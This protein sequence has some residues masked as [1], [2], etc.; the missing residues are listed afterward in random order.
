MIELYINNRLCD[1]DS[2][3]SVRLNRRLIN[4]EELA[5]KDS[6]YSYSVSLPSTHNNNEIF[7]YANTEETGNRFGGKYTAELTINGLRV[8]SGKFRLS[9][10]SRRGYKGNLYLPAPKTIRD[11]FGEKNMNENGSF[12][13]DFTPWSN[14]WNAIS[15]INK[16]GNYPAI[17]PLVLYGLLPKVPDREGNYSNR[18]I[19]DDTV[20]FGIEDIPPSVNVLETVKAVFRN[21]GYR[22]EGN[23]FDDERLA[24][25]YMSYK[26]PTD[27]VQPW[28]WGDLARVLVKGNF[29]SIRGFP[30]AESG[31]IFE[32]E[33]Y[34]AS[35]DLGEFYTVDLLNANNTVI[36][37]VE[38]AGTNTVF[39]QTNTDEND[40]RYV[41]KHLTVTVPRSG[42][43]K[44]RFKADIRLHV[45][46]EDTTVRDPGTGQN[47][48]GART[49][50]DS[51]RNNYFEKKRYEIEVLRDFG[52]GDFGLHSKV[53]SGTF[54]YPNF[55]QNS[56][57]SNGS[58]ANWPKWYPLR[59][60]VLFV[61][62]ASEEKLINGFRWGRSANDRNLG[63]EI[64]ERLP[65]FDP[66]N[67]KIG[68]VL[69]IKN[70]YSWDPKFEQTKK[71]IAATDWRNHYWSYDSEETANPN[72]TDA[73]DLVW[74]LKDKYRVAVTGADGTYINVPLAY[75]G[76][77][78][79]STVIWLDKGESLTV[80]LVT[81]AGDRRRSNHHTK[82][83]WGSVIIDDVNFELEINP[84][85][86]TP[87]WVKVNDYNVSTGP[88]SWDSPSDF[89]KGGIDLIKF[90]PS[91][92]KTNDFLENL[93]KAFN[94]QLTSKGGNLFSLDAYKKMVSPLYV[95]LD[96]I[97][98]VRERINTPLGLPSLYKI[99]FTSDTEE[100]GYF[101]TGENGGGEISTGS[102][103]DKT[104]EQKSFF[105]YNWFKDITGYFGPVS[106]PVISKHEVWEPSEEYGAAMTKRYTD[107][108][109][110]FWYANGVFPDFFPFGRAYVRLAKVKGLLEGRNILNYKDEKLT[111]TANYF[112]LLADG[113]SHYTE[114][115]G[116]L[117]PEQYERLNGS[118]SVMFNGDLYYV[119]ELS[120]YDPTGRN[121]TK[122]KLIRRI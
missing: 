96:G 46:G 58:T 97:T 101:L 104:V 116:Y 90:L 22:I 18:I 61:D 111:I 82:F 47:W 66:K 38:D 63:A 40:P 122:I 43:Y 94:L 28:P 92:I 77:G 85:K 11:I 7:G 121:K 10:I 99:G 109:L 48:I 120:G 65:E 93:C 70:G 55:N 68:A 25:L 78:Q 115:E 29:K 83:N 73:P 71:I 1:T 105:S 2:G 88:M 13:L 100:E 39:T 49:E 114:A 53:L 112:T 74:E 9:E 75:A 95:N 5:P 23:A 27:Y 56:D 84:F 30:G 54:N 37:A 24:G 98:S 60:G 91:E 117:T 72:D 17:F 52:T 6:Q 69:A 79:A 42:L 57:L 44:V 50:K 41:R 119:A 107:S 118:L 16:A 108:A 34:N 51:E 36:Q 33:L 32:R 86:I 4:P 3:F 59:N 8:F 89:E 76:N 80:V 14:T 45:G 35:N 62:P 113:S 15:E 31:Y 20:R 67:E 21:A 106:V 12:F 102:G 87:D 26:N 103:E 81:E 64:N 19:I 110:R